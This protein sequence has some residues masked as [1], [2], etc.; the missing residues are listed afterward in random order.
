M[1]QREPFPACGEDPVG[2]VLVVF[3]PIFEPELEEG[4]TYDAGGYWVATVGLD[5]EGAEGSFEV[6]E[7]RPDASARIRFSFLAE[8]GL[9]IEGEA[10]FESFC[11]A[12]VAC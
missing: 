8:S 12:P 9:R 5:G 2:P 4:R 7:W 11:P 6:I 3:P 1:L 10:V